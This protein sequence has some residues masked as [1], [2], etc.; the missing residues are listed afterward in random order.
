MPR[1]LSHTKNFV[2]N[3]FNTDFTLGRTQLINFDRFSY[4]YVANPKPHKSIAINLY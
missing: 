1:H 4:S 3:K 2:P